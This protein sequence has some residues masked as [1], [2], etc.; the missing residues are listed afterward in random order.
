MPNW[1]YIVS[2]ATFIVA[3]LIEGPVAQTVQYLVPVGVLCNLI[4]NM[5]TEAGVA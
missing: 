2:L 3:L 5:T 1:I 4:D